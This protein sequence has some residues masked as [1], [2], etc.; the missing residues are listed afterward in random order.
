MEIPIWYTPY[1]VNLLQHAPTLRRQ[2]SQSPTDQVQAHAHA[3]HMYT[4]VYINHN[5]IDT[6]YSMYT[7]FLSIYPP[8]YLIYLSIYLSYLILSYRIL[9][10]LS[11]Y[12]SLSLAMYLSI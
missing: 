1:L 2:S 4:I 12:L 3:D 6:V 7:H 8:I 5:H 11:I 9:S 10:Y